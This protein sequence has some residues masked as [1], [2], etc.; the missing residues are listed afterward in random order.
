MGKRRQVAGFSILEV[1]LGCILFASLVVF[2]A[3]IWG[4]HARITAHSRTR[5]VASFIASQRIEDCITAGFDG[6]VALA[7]PEVNPQVQTML[8]TVRGESRLDTYET[9]VAVS[10]HDNPTLRGRVRVVSVRVTFEDQ[11]N[12]GNKSEVVY[13]TFITE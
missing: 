1:L 8:T 11:S 5:V 4:V 10:A 3:N 2:M 9:T 7:D 12:I 6:V 13:R